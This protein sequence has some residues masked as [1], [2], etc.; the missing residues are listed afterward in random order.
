MWLTEYVYQE[1]TFPDLFVA[2]EIIRIESLRF[3][4]NCVVLL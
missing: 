1:S 3:Q 2:E 4:F